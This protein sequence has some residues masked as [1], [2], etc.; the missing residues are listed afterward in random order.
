[1]EDASEAEIQEYFYQAVFD[2]NPRQIRR[3]IEEGAKVNI[4]SPSGHSAV[5]IAALAGYVKIIQLLHECGADVSRPAFD[6]CTPLHIACEDGDMDVIKTLVELGADIN[7]AMSDGCTPMGVAARSGQVETVKFL[8]SVGAGVTKDGPGAPLGLAMIYNHKET[9][10]CIGEILNKCT[11]K[12]ESC[13]TDDCEQIRYC[14]PACQTEGTNRLTKKFMTSFKQSKNSNK[15]KS[16]KGSKS[17]DC[18]SSESASLDNIMLNN[19]A[20]SDQPAS[21]LSTPANENQHDSSRL[22]TIRIL[23]MA[24]GVAI[25]AYTLVKCT[26]IMS[27]FV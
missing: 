24:M 19:S 22:E 7:A 12:C 10:Q 20:E 8:Y 4:R 6:G 18:S 2:G 25:V 15:N 1:M 21:S 3:F 14:S 23:R 16:A 9:V 11:G 17:G 26:D 27:W 5:G 13:G